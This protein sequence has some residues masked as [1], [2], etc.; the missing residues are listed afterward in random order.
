MHHYPHH[1]GDYRTHTAHL[2][3]LEDGAY[4]RLLDIYYM[5]EKPL[6]PDVSAVQR[7]ASARTK[8]EKVAVEAVLREFFTLEEDGWHQGRADEEVAAYQ[9]RA[10]SARRNGKG[11]GRP[12][13]T[14]PKPSDNRPGYFSVSKTADLE[15]QAEPS[16]KLTGNREPGT[17]NREPVRE[18]GARALEIGKDW[19]PKLETVEELRRQRPDLVGEVYE[20]ELTE[21]R[22][23]CR[24]NAVTSHDPEASFLRWMR[25]AKARGG[26]SSETFDQRRI[27][28]GQAA[29]AAVRIP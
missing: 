5:H 14:Q 2:T 4:R 18:K 9:E 11:G 7:L 27:R 21:F 6:P 24:A 12:K 10:D 3:M 25:K 29:L 17:V 26:G 15:T 20:A 23:W 22:L 13:K 1:I 16:E 8:D 28:E 19:K